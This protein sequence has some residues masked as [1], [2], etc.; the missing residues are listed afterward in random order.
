MGVRKGG[1]EEEGGQLEEVSESSHSGRNSSVGQTGHSE[2][3]GG[4]PEQIESEK[5]NQKP[6]NDRDETD[7]KQETPPT[8]RTSQPPPPPLPTFRPPAPLPSLVL[9]EKEEGNKLF[10]AGQYGQA[11]EKYSTAIDMLEEGEEEGA[12]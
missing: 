6:G 8:E 7:N 1:R 5:R 2:V 12:E 4:H 11:M 9:R 10:R 3:T